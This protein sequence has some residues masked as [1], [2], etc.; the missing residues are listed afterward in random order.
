MRCCRHHPGI[1]RRQQDWF[2]GQ[3]PQAKL[4]NKANFHAIKGDFRR[5]E[6]RTLA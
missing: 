1:M 4:C 3:L 5:A 2:E 6:T